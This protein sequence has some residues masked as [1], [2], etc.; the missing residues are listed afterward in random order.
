[1]SKKTLAEMVRE[2]TSRPLPYEGLEALRSIS[3]HDDEAQEPPAT[4]ENPR[5]REDFNLL[6]GAAVSGRKRGSGK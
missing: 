4:G 1:M 6:L 5:H 3:D 2:A